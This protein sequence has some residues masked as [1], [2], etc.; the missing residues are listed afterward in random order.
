M[1]P[2][3]QGDLG[4]HDVFVSFR[5]ADTRYNFVSVLHRELVDRNGIETYIDNRLGG[6]EEIE[7][8]LLKKIEES[9]ISLVIFS[10]NY[11]DSTFC[12]RELAK[13]LECKETKGQIVIPVFYQVDP[14]DI[15]ELRGSYADGLAQREG[16]C[17]A[18][19]VEGWR[20]ALKEIANLKGWDSNVIKH[21][22]MLVDT[23]VDD[24]Q[25]KLHQMPSLVSP[26]TDA[27]RL[28]TETV[29]A[30]SLDM[31]KIQEMKLSP[32][33]FKQMC[34]LRLVEFYFPEMGDYEISRR[35]SELLFP[36]GLE[37]LSKRLRILRWDCCPLESMPS[38]FCPTNLVQL[39]MRNSSNL[40]LWNEVSPL[41]NLKQ[42]EV[43]GSSKLTTINEVLS[44]AP[45][46]EIL[47]LAGC[48]ELRILDLSAVPNIVV[49]DLSSCI[50]LDK[51]PTSIK[52]CTKL[53]R[54]YLRYCD[55]LRTLCAEIGHLFQLV[56]LDIHVCSNLESLPSSIGQLKCLKKLNL[57]GCSKLAM[58]PDSIGSL[59][60]LRKLDLSYTNIDRV[61]VSIKQLSDLKTLYLVYCE[62]L[63][64]LPE[65]PSS[66]QSLHAKGCSSL[67][68]VASIFTE[69]E[70]DDYEVDSEDF[71]FTNCLNLCEDARL[72]I[73]A[74]AKLR[75]QR[76]AT[77]LSKQEYSGEPIGFRLSVPGDRVPKW[78]SYK[79]KAGSSS[80]K[81]KPHCYSATDQELL[82]FAFC[83]VEPRWTVDIGCECECHLITES[84][85][86][87][88]RFSYDRR[89][90]LAMEM[91]ATSWPI[92]WDYGKD[93]G[94]KGR[95]GEKG[96]ARGLANPP[97]T[98]V[99]EE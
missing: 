55:S 3:P 78:F 23:I 4:K 95:K 19:E 70:N 20:H 87:E 76:M 72:T 96:S 18:E 26:S 28:G 58:V 46:L 39:Q 56:E 79:S 99:K 14:T 17:N 50:S 73:I 69:A 91:L 32:R 44:K 6:G 36:K 30:I 84:G 43:T 11:A 21:D 22:T 27:K 5:G 12:L 35:E 66:L 93:D 71:D 57:N 92:K 8:A 9:L 15:Q 74:G 80:V 37:F 13:I 63:R 83:S 52:N 59:V 25:K 33:V 34:N 49:L 77:S 85:T 54:L 98:L 61:P 16:E 42:L 2:P 67:E 68:S 10:K 75:I 81:I 86:R 41:M 97:K 31:S 29:Q 88:L 24:I 40:E 94:R 64:C 38:K 53:T 48:E 62:R 89:G 1:T 47:N 45:N 90:K 7:A 51:V 60:S 65:L 82:G